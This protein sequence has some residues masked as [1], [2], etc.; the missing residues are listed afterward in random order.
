MRDEYDVEKLNPR[1]NQYAEKLKQQITINLNRE[2]V[3]YFK[4]LSAQNGIPH[5]TLINLYLNDVVENKKELK[6]KWE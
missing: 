5:Q 2:T 6:L 1:K 3:D 4:A